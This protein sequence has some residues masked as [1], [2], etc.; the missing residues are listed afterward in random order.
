M[1]LNLNK[2]NWGHSLK[3]KDYKDQQAYNVDTLKEMAKLSE[4]YKKWIEEENQKSKEEFMVSSVGK[5]NPKNHLMQNIEESL[6]QNVMECLGTM[7]N[8]VVF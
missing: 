8:T 1:L 7:L 3:T 6:N 2:V 5:L 4:E